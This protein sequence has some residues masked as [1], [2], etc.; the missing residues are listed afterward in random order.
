MH[1]YRTVALTK[2][3]LCNDLACFCQDRIRLPRG[4]VG[5]D[6]VLIQLTVDGQGPYNFMVDSGL[7]AEIITPQLRRELGIRG[8]GRK[9]SGLGAG[10]AAQAGD[11][12]STLL[13]F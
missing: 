8:S 6:Y 13:L 11:L 3:C 2:L 12:V 10:G 1:V 4:G 7:T 5:R 9:V